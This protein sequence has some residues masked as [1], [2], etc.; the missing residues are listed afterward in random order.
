MVKFINAEEAV[1]L[2]ADNSTVV[3]GGFIGTGVAEEIHSKVEESFLA[4]QSPKN[5]TLVYAAGIGDGKD[6][7]LNH[8]GHSGLLKRV[9]GGHWGLAPKL[10]PLVAENKIEA[11]NFPQG[12]MSHLFRDIAASRPRYITHVGLNTFID[13][14]IAGGKLN[15]AT[16][17]ELVELINFDGKEYLSYKP[18]KID[19]AILKGSYA[20]EDG[21]ISF[22]EEPLTLEV[23]AIA[24][25]TRNCGGKVIVQVKNKVRRGSLEPKLVEIPAALVDYVVIASDEK[26]NMQTFATQ[27]NTSFV[28]GNVI[29]EAGALTFPMSERKVIGRRAAMVFNKN[30]KIVNYGI[31]MPEAIPMVLKEEGLEDALTPTVE[32]GIFGGTPAGGLDFGASYVPQ[33]II[34]QSYMFDYYDG[35][36]IDIAFLGLAQCDA[37]GNINVSKFGTK[38]A[39]TG[40]FVNITQNAKTVVFCGT[41]TAGKLEINIADSKLNIATEGTVKK[42]VQN[43][44]QITYSGELAQKSGQV[45]YYIT[46][47]AVFK[48]EKAGLTLIEIAPGIDL[49]K[50]VL[51]LMDFK[52][53][54][55]A[56]LKTM[57]VEIFKDSAMGLKL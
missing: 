35:G 23:L 55:S 8:Y 40:G 51:A 17:E 21:N 7:G 44:E 10:Q 56:D 29:L 36:G 34:H 3:A 15:E 33:S 4:K 27:F 47:R 11:Y 1:N 9:I 22:E 43:V 5:L 31:G 18:F 25:A 37:A 53:I 48:M 30:H 6:R 24:M 52:P 46:E 38:I 19:I 39:G 41:F 20:D 13:P 14:R 32:P 16:T 45:V 50:D 12:V 28:K 49:E 42:F 54:I 26:K 57:P 2:I